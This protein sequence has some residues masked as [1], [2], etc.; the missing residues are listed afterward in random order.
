LSGERA[1]TTGT[2]M[3]SSLDVAFDTARASMRPSTPRL[4]AL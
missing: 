2:H 4:V 1:L 3:R